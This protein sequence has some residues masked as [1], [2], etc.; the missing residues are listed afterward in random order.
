MGLGAAQFLGGDDLA[1]GGLHQGRAGQEDGALAAD[2]DALVRHGRHIGAACRARAHDAGDLGDALGAHPGLVEEDAAEVVAVGEHL[3]LVRQVGPAGVHQIDARKPVLLSDFLGSE[4]F[5][6]RHGE[7]GSA[8]HRG[9]VGHDHHLAPRYPADAGDD[10]RAGRLAAIEVEGGQGADLQEGRAGV[11]QALHPLPRQE[12]APRRVSFA[13]G[14]GP[15]ERR[16]GGAGAQF[17]EQGAIVG[18]VGGERLRAGI[19]RGLQ[20]GHGWGR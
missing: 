13:R 10:P 19:D 5:L 2:D 14:L 15:A 12:L 8:L 7:V 16:L 9:V 11:E 20:L 17:V 18:G 1:G 3:G 6:H 4:V